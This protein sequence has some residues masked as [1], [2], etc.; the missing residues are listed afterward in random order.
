MKVLMFIKIDNTCF[1]PV[2]GTVKADNF[3]MIDE[4]FF[5]G[6]WLKKILSILIICGT[7]LILNNL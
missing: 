7:V 4:I 2:Q 5:L 6:G 3:E 1:H